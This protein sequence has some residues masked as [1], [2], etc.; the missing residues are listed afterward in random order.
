MNNWRILSFVFLV[1]ILSLT[2]SSAAD[3]TEIVSGEPSFVFKQNS[4][5]DV[6]IRCFDVNDTYCNAQTTCQLSIDD[7]EGLNII[8][9]AS[10]TRNETYYNLTLDSEQTGKNG[11]Y[12]VIATCTGTNSKFSSFSFIVTPTGTSGLLGFYF[13]AIIFSYG[14]LMLGFTK[15]DITI[16][17]LGTFAL[18]LVGLWILFFGLDIHKNFVT[19][20][21]AVLTLGVAFYVSSR[22]AYEYII[23]K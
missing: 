15:E 11:E 18:F 3:V 4:I 23:A 13:L 10:M 2:F 6:K 5:Q 14:V 21:F 19:D 22:M 9:N 16:S 12:S 8:N 1:V 17:L 20:G 7:P